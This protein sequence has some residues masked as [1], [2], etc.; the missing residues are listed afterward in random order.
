[1]S[2]L[3]VKQFLLGYEAKQYLISIRELFRRNDFAGDTSVRIENGFVLN[4]IIARTDVYSV[5]W[6]NVIRQ[7][8]TIPEYED[9]EASSAG[10]TVKFK[11]SDQSFEKI[12]ELMV[13]LSNALHI[14]IYRAYAVKLFLKNYYCIYCKK[15]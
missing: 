5:D 9:S 4:K 6:E 7:K 1:M 14:R 10:K 11:L 13:F 12:N 8:I 3:I 2:L 15:E